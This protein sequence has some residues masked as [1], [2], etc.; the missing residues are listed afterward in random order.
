MRDPD[1]TVHATLS[2]GRQVVRYDRSGK[3]YAETPGKKDDRDRLSIA[4][5]SHLAMLPGATAQLGLPG[6]Q[7][8][9]AKVRQIDAA[10]AAE[11]EGGR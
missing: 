7:Q 1:R 5:A 4:D 2:N 10:R 9:D 8:F 6:G 11:L 3:W